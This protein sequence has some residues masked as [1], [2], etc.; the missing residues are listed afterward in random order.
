MRKKSLLRTTVVLIIS[1]LVLA[2]ASQMASAQ[3]SQKCR[4][5]VLDK[6]HSRQ[7]SRYRGRKRR[8]QKR[9]SDRRLLQRWHTQRCPAMRLGRRNTNTKKHKNMV[10]DKQ[11]IHLFSCVGDVD[12]DDK[13]EIVTGGYYNDGTRN[14]A[15]LCVWNGAT[16]A[17][18]NVKTWYWTSN[19]VIYSVAVGDVD[20]DDKVEIV[21][22]GCHHDGTQYC[23]S[24]ASG[25]AQPWHSKT[26]RPVTGQTSW[27]SYFYSLRLETWILT[28]TSR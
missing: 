14:V 1:I 25:M 27:Q 17:V 5:L 10:L 19:T 6:Q 26:L 22:G 8:R 3:N 9:N 7:L 20:G 11:H 28:A 2:T 18:E 16:L 4:N 24:C 12:G 23:P 13:V 15:Q 21:T